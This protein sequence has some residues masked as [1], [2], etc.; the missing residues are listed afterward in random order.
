MTDYSWLQAVLL[1]LL[2]GLTEF[3]PVSSTGHLILLTEILDFRGP[4]GRVFEVAIQ[5]GAILAICVLYAPRLFALAVGTLDDPGA[6][7]FALGILLGFLPAAVVG[8]LAH[9]TIKALLF[10][11][12]VVAISL[13]A[14]GIAILVVEKTRPVPTWLSAE[15]FPLKIAFA[16]GCCQVLAMI[17][18]VS[19]SGA[20]IMGA[21]MLGA[22]RRAAAEF[23]FFLAIPTML[24]AT[25]YDLYKNRAG[26]DEAGIVLIAIGFTCAFFSALLVVRALVAW[27]GQN[28]FA[29][30]AWYRIGL[31]SLVLALLALR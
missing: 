25:V 11:P 20:T 2:E 24:G 29:P 7:R 9:S 14:G 23:S 28:G 10:S 1:G 13:I 19:R 4:P 30:F 22:N 26:L 16:I 18:G 12:W 15:R 31:G 3:I 27:V 5:F 17:P 6:R 8:V 21:L